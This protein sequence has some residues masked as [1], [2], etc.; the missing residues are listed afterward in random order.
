[1]SIYADAA[2]AARLF[3]DVCDMLAAAPYPL[4]ETSR[5][6]EHDIAE[7]IRSAARVRTELR[8]RNAPTVSQTR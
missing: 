2:K 7:L 8:R 3:A 6:F 4:P 5:N 1:M